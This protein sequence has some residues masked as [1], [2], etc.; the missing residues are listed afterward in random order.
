MVHRPHSS[1]LRTGRHSQ[2]GGIYLVTVVTADRKPVF[3][4]FHAA[5]KLIHIL[6][7]PAFAIRTSTLAYVVMPD[8]LHWLFQLG[9][10]ETLSACIQR[11]KSLTTKAIGPELWQKGF[12]DH[13]IRRDEDLPAVARYIVANPVRAGLVTRVG[14]YPHWDA[15]WV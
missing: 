1:H 11:I 8:H 10:V 15:I 13:A 6:H 3:V 5:R 2:A 12:H 7:H 4:D 9:E 14:V